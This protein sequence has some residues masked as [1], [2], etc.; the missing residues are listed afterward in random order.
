MRLHS[1]FC[2]KHTAAEDVIIGRGKSNVCIFHQF[3]RNLLGEYHVLQ[4]SGGLCFGED[5]AFIDSM[6]KEII[7]HGLCFTDHLVAALASRRDKESLLSRLFQLLMIK[8]KGPVNSAPQQGQRFPSL[9][10]LHPRM[11]IKS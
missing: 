7:L 2:G 10:T 9:P 1:C 8:F 6:F 4:G 5:D 11:T 3:V